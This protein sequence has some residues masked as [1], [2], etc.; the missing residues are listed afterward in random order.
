M[1]SGVHLLV[2]SKDAEADKA[3]FRNVLK[4][5]NVDVGHGWLIFGLPPSELAVHPSE[6]DYHEIYLMCDDIEAFAQE[7]SKQKIACSKIQDQG[8]GQLIQL[9]LPGGGRLGVYQPRHER[10]KPMKIKTTTEKKTS[11]KSSTKK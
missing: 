6:N 2:Y 5:T 8:Y 10:P 1:I 4:F 9:T 7:M 11:K 3:F